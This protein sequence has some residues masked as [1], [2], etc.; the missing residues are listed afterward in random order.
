MVGILR[1]T[2]ASSEPTFCWKSR[3]TTSPEAITTGKKNTAR[4]NTWPRIFWL[5]KNAVN[6][7]K[8]R[9]IGTSTRLRWITSTRIGTNRSSTNNASRKL[10]HPT[11][12]S[13]KPAI[14]STVLKAKRIEWR[15]GLATNTE[16]PISQGRMNR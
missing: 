10:A 16:K 7:A 12:L 15:N 9:I 4:K 2:T 6:S 14:M 8:V 1:P 5:T 11:G 13:G 3:S